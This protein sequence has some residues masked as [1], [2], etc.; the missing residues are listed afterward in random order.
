MGRAL[1]AFFFFLSFLVPVSALE[2]RLSPRIRYGTD[3]ELPAGVLQG[4]PDCVGEGF[5]VCAGAARFICDTA[6]GTLTAT[7]GGASPA[8]R[9]PP[10]SRLP[11]HWG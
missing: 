10:V 5:G 4:G 2:G 3:C 7:M 9:L 6:E 1:G 8:E 11:G